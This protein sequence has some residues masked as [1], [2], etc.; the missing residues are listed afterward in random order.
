MKTFGTVLLDSNLIFSF[1]LT[2][3][4]RQTPVTR[5]VQFVLKQPG[6][7]IVPLEQL[8]EMD[9]TRQEKECLRLRIADDVWEDL[10]IRARRFGTV[11]TEPV[12]PIEGATRDPK[13]DYL[14][15]AAIQHDV[16]ILVSGDKDLLALAEFLE[17]PRIMSP[18]QFV[19]EFGEG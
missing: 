1:L 11:L 4:D 13:D 10:L 8:S 16:D 12:E 19:A 2:D 9:D 5:T 6:A 18:A 14:I 17:L 15:A 7:W 3:A